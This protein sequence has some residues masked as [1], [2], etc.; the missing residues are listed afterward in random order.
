MYKSV[1]W[2]MG[3]QVATL[4]AFRPSVQQPRRSARIAPGG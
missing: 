3:S 4:P 1:E 2:M